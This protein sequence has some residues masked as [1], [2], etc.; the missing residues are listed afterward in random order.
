VASGVY[1]YVLQR[2]GERRV[3]KVAVVR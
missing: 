1:L 2:D 3:G